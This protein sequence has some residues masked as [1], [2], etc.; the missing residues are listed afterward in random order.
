MFGFTLKQKGMFGTK[1]RTNLHEFPR[2]LEG[3]KL[4]VAY[5]IYTDSLLSSYYHIN[6]TILPF[7]ITLIQPL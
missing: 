5:D 4:I 2:D 3:N 7:V 1:E 6:G